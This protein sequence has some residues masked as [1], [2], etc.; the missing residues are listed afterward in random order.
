MLKNIQKG[1]SKFFTMERV[2]ILLVIIA[3][4]M[5]LGYYTDAKKMIRDSMETGAP[6]ESEEAAE[7]IAAPAPV[8]GYKQQAVANP[9]DL[10]PSDANSKFAEL[11]PN[12]VSSDAVMTPDL[13]Q[14]GYHIGL[15]TVG[16]T[17]RNANLQLRSDPVISKKDVGPFLNSTIEPDLARTPL[18][19]G[20]R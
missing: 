9:A 2:L 17:L 3:L 12:T 18:E 1:L 8:E 6:E 19:L 13:L 5:G 16:Q 10:L 4:I 14:A 11:N 20:E 15:D 7:E